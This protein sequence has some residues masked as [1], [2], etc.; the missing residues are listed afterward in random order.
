MPSEPGRAECRLVLAPV[1]RGR[2]HSVAFLSTGFLH[3]CSRVS[4][5]L[6]ILHLRDDV[7]R[8]DRSG[9]VSFLQS[10]CPMVTALAVQLC[11]S[12]PPSRLWARVRLRPLGGSAS[13]TWAV[14][15]LF[16]FPRG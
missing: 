3:C 9:T 16:A 5:H 2:V 1:L 7:N 6:V 8:A 4:G 14:V 13:L 15:L 12:G 11:C 10:R